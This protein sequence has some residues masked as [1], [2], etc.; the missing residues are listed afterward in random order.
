MALQKQAIPISFAKGSDMRPFLF[1]N[2]LSNRRLRYRKHLGYRSLVFAL[3]EKLSNRLNVCNRKLAH[4]VSLA[5]RSALSSFRALVCRISFCVP[6]KQVLRIYTSGIVAVVTNKP[7]SGYVPKM[8][9]PRE[10]MGLHLAPLNWKSPIS[11]VIKAASPNPTPRRL[12]NPPPKG[13]LGIFWHHNF[14]VLTS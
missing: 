4:R 7:P 12:S 9:G 3:G 8:N 11:R 2:Y 5:G 10:S 14:L 1:A 6:D 13:S